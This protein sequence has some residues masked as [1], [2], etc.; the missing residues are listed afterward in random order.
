MEERLKEKTERYI[1]SQIHHYID[2]ERK[3]RKKERERE[4]KSRKSKRRKKEK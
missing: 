4:K 1:D 3:S 2:R